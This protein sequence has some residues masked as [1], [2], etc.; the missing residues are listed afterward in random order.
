MR[1]ANAGIYSSAREI[2][3]A[4]LRVNHLTCF[5]QTPVKAPTYPTTTTFLPE[6][7]SLVDKVPPPALNKFKLPIWDPDCC[8][9]AIES[10]E[11]N[12]PGAAEKD[13]QGRRCDRRLFV[14]EDVRAKARN[15]LQPVWMETG[16]LRVGLGGTVQDQRHVLMLNADNAQLWSPWTQGRFCVRRRP[17]GSRSGNAMTRSCTTIRRDSWYAKHAER[18][19]SWNSGTLTR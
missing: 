14:R 1:S 6:N 5:W 18:R 12:A 3:L 11:E 2:K 4:A 8:Q 7:T 13:L 15:M 16:W 17:S 9:Q 10:L 19:S